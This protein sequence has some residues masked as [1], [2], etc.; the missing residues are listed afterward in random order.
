M[1]ELR[2]IAVR[3]GNCT[4]LYYR[5]VLLERQDRMR[6]TPAPTH[7]DDRVPA[8]KLASRVSWRSTVYRSRRVAAAGAAW[9]GPKIDSEIYLR[10]RLLTA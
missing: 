6:Q 8:K 3:N 5:E 1:C 7:L 4:H 9:G 10:S 2:P